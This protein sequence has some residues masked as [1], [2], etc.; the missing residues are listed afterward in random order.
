MYRKRFGLT[1]HPLPR[2]TTGKTFVEQTPGYERLRRAFDHLIEE[3]GLGVLTGEAGV[4]KTAALRHLCAKLPQPDYLVLYLCDTAVSPLDLYRTL[5]GE[6]G[7]R[8]SHRRGQLWTDIKKA[9][10]HLVDERSTA[11][12]VILDEAQH[13]SDRFLVDLSGFL[14][15]AF[16]SRDVLTLWLSGLPPLR[17]HLQMQQHAP[18]AMR[19]AAQVHLDPVGAR[20]AFAALVSASLEA[21]GATQKLLGDPALEM[22]FRASRGLLR[23]ASK[24]LRAALRAAH[25]ADQSFVDEHTMERAIE[26]VGALP[27]QPR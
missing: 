1:G 23:P 16:D 27:G 18:L 13:L 22:L 2:N 7:L 17:Q 6:L 12:V 5:A 8:P 9:L 10:V 20:D 25:D 11:P 26:Q 21:V 14:N 24:I 15:F 3:P 4:G 19:I